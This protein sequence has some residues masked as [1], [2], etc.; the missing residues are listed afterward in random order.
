VKIKYGVHLYD[1]TTSGL[2]EACD[3]NIVSRIQKIRNGHIMLYSTK[4][5][6]AWGQATFHRGGN[7]TSGCQV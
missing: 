5:E 3:P 4:H 6:V 7:V 2:D 1:I